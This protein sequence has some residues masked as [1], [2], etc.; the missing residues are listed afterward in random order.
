MIDVLS[1]SNN[2]SDCSTVAKTLCATNKYNSATSTSC[3]SET[4]SLGASLMSSRI[5]RGQ[6]RIYRSEVYDTIA[7]YICSNRSMAGHNDSHR[8]CMSQ[9]D[10]PRL[11]V[12]NI[13][14]LCPA[15][16]IVDLFYL[17]TVVMNFVGW[18]IFRHRFH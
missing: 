6:S 14:S 2:N 11:D 16:S 13:A 17:L 3:S 5:A 1:F 4:A 9:C 18:F 8:V 7:G 15:V 12:L 10:V